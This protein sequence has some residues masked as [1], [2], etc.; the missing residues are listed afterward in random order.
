MPERH[1]FEGIIRR[2]KELLA[3]M[4]KAKIAMQKKVASK[5]EGKKDNMDET[6]EKLIRKN[7][8]ETLRECNI[9]DEAMAKSLAKMNLEDGLGLDKE[10]MNMGVDCE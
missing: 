8:E 5:Q 6:M 3:D 9:D 10:Y 7:I 1:G 4:E 2:E